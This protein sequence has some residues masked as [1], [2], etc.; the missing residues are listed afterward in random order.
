M[1]LHNA[2]GIIIII[3]VIMFTCMQWTVHSISRGLN[4]YT[5]YYS[6]AA[7]I[8]DVL[9]KQTNLIIPLIAVDLFN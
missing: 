4:S 3:D 5:M 2:I 8:P 7:S 6:N 9:S 1:T